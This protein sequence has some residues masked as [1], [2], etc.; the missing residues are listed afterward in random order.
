MTTMKSEFNFNAAARQILRDFPA[1]GP[2]TIFVSN[3]NADTRLARGR[4]LK[5]TAAHP[6][7]IT[8]VFNPKTQNL[9][10]DKLDE[11]FKRN[12]SLA[13][14]FHIFDKSQHNIIAFNEHDTTLNFLGPAANATMKKL[15]LNHEAGHLV[16][17]GALPL[18]NHTSNS[19]YTEAAPDSFA[20]FRVIQ[21]DPR[22]IDVV[23]LFSWRRAMSF[24]NLGSGTHI[25]T[26]V[27]DEIV[28]GMDIDMIRRMSP[29]KTIETAKT[30]AQTFTTKFEDMVQAKLAY[31][32]FRSQFSEPKTLNYK[33]IKNLS[34]T[35]LASSHK[36][37]FQ[38]GA[39]LMQPFLDG[40]PIACKGQSFALP[41]QMASE[42]RK[43]FIAKAKAMGDEN[44][45]RALTVNAMTPTTGKKGTHFPLSIRM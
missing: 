9:M 40:I 38:I 29:L 8:T 21:E 26:A 24:V 23:R 20:A 30:V 7:S 37:T 13:F 31:K 10:K 4:R 12:T 14:P 25:T 5:A 16:V 45:I 19:L 6:L 1:L 43:K 15:I 2:T 17:P 35:A 3:E 28:N 22:A 33:L 44:T 27:L 36:F 11:A 34:E 39:R 42:Y 32:P 18:M 41:P